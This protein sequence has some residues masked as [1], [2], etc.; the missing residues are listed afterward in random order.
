VNVER[1]LALVALVSIGIWITVAVTQSL[2]VPDSDCLKY[3]TKTVS[4]W[5][6]TVV[7]NGQVMACFDASTGSVDTLRCV[8]MKP[9]PP[10]L[11][12]ENAP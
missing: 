12:S 8:A 5:F 10:A 7:V 2:M 6:S 9:C 3:E 4:P 1:I 11:P